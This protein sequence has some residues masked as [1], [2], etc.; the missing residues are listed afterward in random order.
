MFLGSG[1]FA[2]PSFEALLDSGHQVLA[3]VTQPDKEKGR[4]RGLAPPPLKPVA[5]RRRVP[6]LQPR[7]IKEPEVQAALRSLA[8]DLQVVVAYGQ[9]LPLEVIDIPPLG[10]VNVHAS[11]LPRYR[12][13]APIQW[14]IVR[15][16]TETGVT[17][18]L[19]DQGLDTGP[20]LLARAAPIG[21][22][23]TAVELAPR[24][25]VLG[26]EALLSTLDGL[27]SGALVPS[28]QDHARATLAPLIRKAD[29]RLDWS[30]PAE[31]IARRVRGFHPWPGVTCVC[32]GRGLRVLRAA[33]AGLGPGGAGEIVG[34]DREGILVACGQSTRLRLIEVQPESR[35]PMLASA[36]AAGARLPVGSCFD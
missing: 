16:E 28:P 12:G 31:E 7:R 32:R 22:Q 21:P 33:A 17:T 8:P 13:A 29:G 35:Q 2:I 30:Q 5:E 23:E 1:A 36:F 14:A 19:I 6:V 4:G 11:L 18:M 20:T 26:A 24:L 27:A 15:G 9:I 34:L 3:L 25:A 10:T